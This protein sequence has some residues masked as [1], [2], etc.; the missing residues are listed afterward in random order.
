MK[1]SKKLRKRY[2]ARVRE[3]YEDFLD[4]IN[5]LEE[6]CEHLKR[7]GG[8]IPGYHEQLE[9]LRSVADAAREMLLEQQDFRLVDNAPVVL[10]QKAHELTFQVI[11]EAHRI[12]RETFG[13]EPSD[14][15][16]IQSV[17]LQ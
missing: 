1:L 7:I 8:D 12:F 11:R 14:I 10:D 6:R 3:V 9:E 16:K 15:H 2:E 17:A 4:T 13:C 5:A